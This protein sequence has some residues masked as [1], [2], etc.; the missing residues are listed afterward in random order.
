MHTTKLG[1]LTKLKL[2]TQYIQ[3]ASEKIKFLL[4]SLEND[5]A[6]L[7]EIAESRHE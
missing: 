3:E 7:I 4:K 2:A 5:I 1:S 6:R